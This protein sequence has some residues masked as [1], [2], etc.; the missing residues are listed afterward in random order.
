MKMIGLSAA[1]IYNEVAF[2]FVLKTV[3]HNDS[4]KCDLTNI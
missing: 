2:S 4:A 1:I 3:T